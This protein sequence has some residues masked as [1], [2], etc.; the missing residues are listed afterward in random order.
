[1]LGSGTERSLLGTALFVAA[2]TL[3]VGCGSSGGGGGTKPTFTPTPTPTP[4][5]V[6][7]A[8]PGL[9]SEILSAAVA[10]DPAGQVSVEFTVTDDAGNP[11]TAT[12]GQ[13]TSDQQARVRLTMA[14]LERYS[15]GGELGTIFFRYVNNI[16][17][18]RPTYDRNGTLT[19][20]DPA[21]GTYQ[22]TFATALP[23]DY[24]RSLTYTIG[25]QVDRTFDGQLLG[26]NP[27][28]SFVPAGGT[29][30][31]WQD[32]LTAECNTCHQP[33]ILH[34]NRREVHLCKLCHTEAAVDE[35][36]TS[37]DF[38][39]MIHMI[40]AGK[41]LPS[42]VLGP[43]GSA[44]EIYSSFQKQYVV[45]AEKEADG[46]VIGVGF[47]RHLEEC[48]P[49]H[50]EGPTANFY[51][52][53]PAAAAC[54]TCHDNVNPSDKTTAAGPPGTNHPP[55]GF[56]DGQCAACHTATQ[57]Q[58][59]D[60]SVPGSHV[61]PA[62]STALKGLNIDITELA[63]H[64][65]GQAPTVSFRVTDNAGNPMRDLSVLGRLGFA[66]SGP[67]TDYTEV[68]TATAV[69]SG[70]SGTLVGPDPSGL[71][72]Y[73]LPT[74]VPTLA[75][76]S[77]AIGAEAR[78]VVQLTET[79]SATEAAEN[80]VVA[81]SVD[82]SPVEPHRV[83]VETE[84]C[85][86]CHGQFSKDF[87]VHG[88]LRNQIQYCDICHNPTQSDASRR[89]LDPAAVAAG[90]VNASINSRVLF[91]SLHR[92]EDLQ[93]QPYLVYGRG[94]APKNYTIY[95]FGE[96]RYPGDLRL[97]DTCHVGDSQL[98]PPYPGT[99][100]PTLRTMLDPKT[101]DVIPA[102]PPEVQ[103]ITS[104]CIA[105]HD[106]DAAIAHAEA[107]TAPDGTESCEVCHAEGRP[108]A[109]SIVHAVAPVGP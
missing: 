21:T 9:R 85:A 16:N 34:G 100:L 86:R 40:H 89:S 32:T 104:V 55:G 62:R 76:G 83:I 49:C 80:P 68:V 5:P 71:F 46:K 31:V 51:R 6:T 44:Y 25:I 14:Q 58:E 8:G 79:K 12:L 3:A 61:V 48:L 11:I 52:E 84:N 99:A 28:Y 82:G 18:T 94:P 27:V 97:C 35:K 54:A 43:P 26:A 59:F 1:M 47:P 13:A 74:P 90:E 23:A 17:A 39:N 42:V 53:K 60:L 10:A 63:D 29:P 15:G 41:E 72:E 33:L 66:M 91:H 81:F 56:S 50:A 75:T 101:G 24:D 78:Q 22:Y 67:T 30:E 109:V 103:P 77:W 36:G 69:G 4:P 57:T 45:F 64:D 95:D 2:L 87:S 105:C 37:V 98:L 102:V 108:F 88:N 96:I 7:P 65:A 93:Q 107:Q 106:S 20:V 70:A 92:G 19:P 38:R 73:T